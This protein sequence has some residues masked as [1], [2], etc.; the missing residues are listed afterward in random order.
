VRLATFVSVK[1]D[2]ELAR[3]IGITE[4]ELAILIGGDAD[5]LIRT[6]VASKVRALFG[7]RP[8]NPIGVSLAATGLVSTSEAMLIDALE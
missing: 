5:G 7:I 2:A 4:A 8:E 1:L 3:R 6:S